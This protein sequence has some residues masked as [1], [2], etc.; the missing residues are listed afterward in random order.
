MIEQEIK[1]LR[2]INHCSIVRFFNR[3]EDDPEYCYIIMELCDKMNLYCR[4]HDK[5]ISPTLIEKINI[6]KRLAESFK[7][8]HDKQINIVHRDVKPENILFSKD[9]EINEVKVSDFGLSRLL[10][11]NSYV[12]SGIRGSMGF[13]A[14]ELQKPTYSPWDASTT[15]L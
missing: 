7:Y 14:P 2:E 12:P 3:V 15:I 4:V 6:L 1:A 9:G 5:L 13:I 10:E 8:L 11:E